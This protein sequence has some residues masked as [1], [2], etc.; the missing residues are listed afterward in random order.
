VIGNLE[1]IIKVWVMVGRTFGQRKPLKRLTPEKRDPILMA[2]PNPQQQLYARQQADQYKRCNIE[3]ATQEEILLML[4]DG[5]IRFLVIAKKALADKD[6]EKYSNHLIKTQ[7][8]V[9]E[10]MNSLDIELGGET[11]QNLYNLYEY[12]HYR[13]VQA[14][15]KRDV[16]M[17]EEVLDHLRNLKKT[18]EEAIR[19]A[20]R[21]QQLSDTDPDLEMDAPDDDNTAPSAASA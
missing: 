3:T 2:Y 11:A 4:Y 17:V 9:L 6:I 14:N 1:E 21:T 20:Q 7:Q 16:T 5:A 8:I 10:F 15:I 12:F 18:W 19:V 13:L